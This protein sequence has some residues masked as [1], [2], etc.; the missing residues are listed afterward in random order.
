[1]DVS[2]MFVDLF[3]L[4]VNDHRSRIKRDKPIQF[5]CDSYYE[6]VRYI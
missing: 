5:T 6:I 1:M 3:M 2:Y 4:Y